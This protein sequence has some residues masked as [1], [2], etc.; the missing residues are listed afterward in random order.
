[1]D[2]DLFVFEHAQ[3]SIYLN[4]IAGLCGTS[5]QKGRLGRLGVFDQ[6]TFREF[7]SLIKVTKDLQI[8]DAR[9]VQ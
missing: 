8:V 6:L 1:M 9:S 7:L 2:R 5:C 4:A 3:M